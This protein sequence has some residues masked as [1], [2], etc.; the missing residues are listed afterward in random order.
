MLPCSYTTRHAA[1]RIRPLKRRTRATPPPRWIRHAHAATLDK[2][3]KKIF[4]PA[5]HK[6]RI[7]FR[8]KCKA[9]A[10]QTATAQRNAARRTSH[11]RQRQNETGHDTKP[12]QRTPGNGGN[13]NSQKAHAGHAAGKRQ[14]KNLRGRVTNGKNFSVESAGRDNASHASPRETEGDRR[15]LPKGCARTA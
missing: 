3:R 10:K 13:G 11:A 9:S 1:A 7:F 5:C 8:S 2:C 14:K 6:R 12:Q 15:H 4:C